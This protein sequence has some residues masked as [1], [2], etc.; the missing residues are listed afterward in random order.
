MVCVPLSYCA[1]PAAESL[2][3]ITGRLPKLNLSNCLGWCLLVHMLTMLTAVSAVQTSSRSHLRYEAVATCVAC[4]TETALN[5]QPCHLI[6]CLARHFSHTSTWYLHTLLSVHI[7][8]FAACLLPVLILQGK[9]KQV[10][11]LTVGLDLSEW[12]IDG[13]TASWR[14][15]ANDTE[16]CNCRASDANVARA[17]H[18]DITIGTECG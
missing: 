9:A 5:T 10:S 4:K 17:M 8:G 2:L 3:G 7:A 13:P 1:L 11:K 6:M 18:V 16:V 14:H 15:I 12:L